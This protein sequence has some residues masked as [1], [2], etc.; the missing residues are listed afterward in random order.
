M[1]ARVYEIEGHICISHGMNILIRELGVMHDVDSEKKK[2]T[3][4]HTASSATFD[5]R[6]QQP[7]L[8]RTDARSN[9]LLKI[10]ETTD[11]HENAN[12]LSMPQCGGGEYT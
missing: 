8:C 10:Q 7:I 5:S 9:A 2:A 12:T 11:T 1:S 3:V 4:K 6:K